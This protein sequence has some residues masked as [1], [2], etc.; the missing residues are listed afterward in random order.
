ML[1]W[2]LLLVFFMVYADPF[3]VEILRK[4]QQWRYREAAG[5]ADLCVGRDKQ[6][7]LVANQ[8]LVPLYLCSSFAQVSVP[9]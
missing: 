8:R 9:L 3:C 6:E 5:R 7:L 4:T 2:I 1:T